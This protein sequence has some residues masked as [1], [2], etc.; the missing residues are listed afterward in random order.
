MYRVQRTLDALDAE[1]EVLGKILGTE[2]EHEEVQRE[3]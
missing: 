1:S 3:K 2:S